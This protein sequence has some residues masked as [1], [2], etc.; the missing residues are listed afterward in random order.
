MSKPYF[1]WLY[2]NHFQWPLPFFVFP[3]GEEVKGH[4]SSIGAATGAGAADGMYGR[5]VTQDQLMALAAVQPTSQSQPQSQPLE[6]PADTMSA[7]VAS[8]AGA[9]DFLLFS[10]PPAPALHQQTSHIQASSS[11]LFNPSLSQNVISSTNN[12]GSM[13]FQQPQPSGSLSNFIHQASSPNSMNN[14][15]NPNVVLCSGASTTVG[16]TTA[17][18][19]TVPAIRYRD[20]KLAPIQKLSVDLIKTYK[21]NNEVSFLL[22]FLA[23]HATAGHIETI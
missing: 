6:A 22:S 23:E 19:T 16:A 10:S 5:I 21:H 1:N 17:T 7:A 2:S 3:L 12:P 4:D 9:N 18:G 20:H 15:S 11:S 8:V 14:F 13:V